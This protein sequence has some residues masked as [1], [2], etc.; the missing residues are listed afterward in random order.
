MKINDLDEANW[1]NINGI[2]RVPN[3]APKE[4]E[5]KGM[6]VMMKPSIFL[7]LA[8]KIPGSPKSD[9]T[10]YIKKGGSIAMPYLTILVPWSKDSE[11]YDGNDKVSIAGHEGRHRTLAILQTEGD[12]PIPVVLFFTG[13]KWKASHLD[14]EFVT[15]IKKQL[16]SQDGVLIKGPLWEAVGRIVKGVNTTVDVGVNQ[17]S[18]EANK[19]GHKVTKNGVPP[20]L[21][22]NGKVKEARYTASEWAIIEGGHTLEEA[23]KEKHKLFDWN[24]Y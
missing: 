15:N 6:Q 23:T 11:Y 19:L 16:V 17:T 4:I 20:F 8:E 22:T 7:K 24:K 2:G 13:S 1:D 9:M 12:A 5:Y 21:R 3:L 10:D 18:I 14:S